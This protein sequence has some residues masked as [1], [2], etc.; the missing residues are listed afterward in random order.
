MDTEEELLKVIHRM[1]DMEERKR[2]KTEALYAGLLDAARE[3]LSLLRQ[4]YEK[5]HER[6]AKVEPRQVG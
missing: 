1:L 2:E 3:L 4:A 5:S 6:E